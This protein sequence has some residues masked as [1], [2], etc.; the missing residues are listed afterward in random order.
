MAFT[1]KFCPFCGGGI[2]LGDSGTF[3]CEECDKRIVRSRSNSNA[4]LANKPYGEEYS[5]IVA[6][7][8]INPERAVDSIDSIIDDADEPNADMYFTR[9]IAYAAMG[10][11]GKAHNDWKKGLDMI[12][13]LRFIDSYIVAISRP[14]VDIICMK[15]REFMDFKPVDYINNISNEFRLKAD[16]PCRGIF[17]ITIYR[18]FRMDLQAGKFTVDDDIYPEIIPRLV[19]MIL[20]YGRNF[21][22][23]DAIIEEVLEDFEYNLET[24]EED[25]NLKLHL[26]SM[27]VDK[28]LEL[29]KDFSD[30]HLRRIFRHWN[31]ENMYELEYWVDQLMIAVKDQSRLQT[32]RRLRLVDVGEFD[33]DAAAEYYA[34]KFLLISETGE[35]LSEESEALSEDL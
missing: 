12:T 20:A 18:N 4:F 23:T 35:D 26:C 6:M 8:S 19:H 11:E 27:I 33:L 10:E 1:I 28:Y 30:A 14:I 3:V 32:L 25:D 13:D 17:Y 15:E 9:G 29:S 31:D 22:T 2:S 24:Y 16:V 21:Q 34:R 7:A 5:K